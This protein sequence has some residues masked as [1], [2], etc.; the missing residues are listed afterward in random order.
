MFHPSKK[1]VNS[2]G[3]GAWSLA[4][5]KDN[6]ITG[7]IDGSLKL[8]DLKDEK[9]PI[10]S[11]KRLK[12]GI[13]SI[14]STSDG[15][16]AIACYQDSTIRFFDLLNQKELAVLDPGYFEAYSISL[17][18]GEDILA[19]GNSRG[20]VNVWSMQEGHEKVASL[21]SKSNFIAFTCFSNDGK[22][23]TSSMDGQIN[24]FDL[25]QQQITFKSDLH[26][27]PV[28][29]MSINQ[30]SNLLLSAS[31][32]KQVNIFDLR[33]NKMI[34][35]FSHEGMVFTVDFS[36]DSRYFISGTTENK[37]NLW[38]LSMQKRTQIFSTHS[39]LIW[40]VQFQKSLNTSNFASCGDDGIIQI[41]SEFNNEMN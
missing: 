26:S 17:S 15:S 3:D 30:E 40:N 6:L 34:R 19:S 23:A 29:S 25:N 13:T 32:D 38:D 31:D 11:S 8:W 4:W 18:P 39:D 33:S 7:S 28:R 20:N 41:Y 9:Q 36:P 21:P 35:S 5:C 2:N 37:V 16:K 27:L 12:I 1:F 24:I 10:F 14:T 22:L